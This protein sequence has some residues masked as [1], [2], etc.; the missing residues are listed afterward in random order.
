MLVHPYMGNTLV[1][2]PGTRIVETELGAI[3][4]SF[5]DPN[6]RFRE[7]TVQALYMPLNGRALG[8]LRAKVVDNKSFISF[9]NQRDLEVLLDIASPGQYCRWLGEE[10]IEPGAPGWIG[11]AID[12]IDLADDLFDREL[13]AR[14]QLPDGACLPEG[15]NLERRVHDGRY[16]DFIETLLLLWD[17]DPETGTGPDTRLETISR[18][19]RSNERTPGRERSTLWSRL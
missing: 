19:W 3:G 17:F 4:E 18:R 15:L 9:C 8:G 5:K 1:P 12:S 10:Y 11:L 14:A 16:N 2:I 6:N 13:E 7:W